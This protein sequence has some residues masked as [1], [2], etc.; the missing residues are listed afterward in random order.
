MSRIDQET[1]N[2]IL[3]AADIVDVVGDFVQLKKSGA[4]Y[5][6]LC[7]FHNERTP[8][9]SVSK[10]KGLCKCFSCG[11]GGSAVGFLM[12]L[13]QLSYVEALKYLAKKYN[14]EV[15]EHEMTDAERE[16]ATERESLFAVNTFALE[17]FEHNLLEEPDGRDIGLSYFRERGISDAAIKRFRLGYSLD[18]RD[19]LLQAAKSKGYDEKYLI[20]TG[21]CIKNDN[22][23]VYDRFKGRVMYPVFTVSGKVVAFG[24]RTL[25]SD[26]NVAKY[27]NSPESLIYTKSNELYGLYQAKQ[28]IVRKNKCILVEGY[29]DVISMS[30]SGIENVVASSGTSLTE[31]QIRLLHRFSENVTVI[32]DSDAAGI[33]ASL[34]G[35]DMLLS[36]G[37]K[38]K[39]LLLPDGDDPDS[40]A[41][42]HTLEEI[43]AYI[44]ENETDFIRFKTKILLEGAENDPIQ[45]AAVITDIVKSI[46]F[47]PD[48]ISQLVYIGECSRILQID[49]KVLKLEVE[50][51]ISQRAEAELKSPH[52]TQTPDQDAHKAA[53]DYGTSMADPRDRRAAVSGKAFQLLVSCEMNL[54]RYVLKYGMVD[55]CD[56]MN[57]DGQTVPLKLIDYVNDELEADNIEL[58]SEA[59]K[60]VFEAV[61]VQVSQYWAEDEATFMADLDKRREAFWQQGQNEIQQ[62]AVDLTDIKKK[63]I[64]L[65]EECDNMYASECER[66]TT[67]YLESRLA[68]SADDNVRRLTT[69]LVSEKYQLSKV[70][71]KYSK[72][73]TERDR[74]ID[75]VP[76]AIATLKEAHITVL[77]A[78]ERERLINLDKTQPGYA[79][80]A[81]ECLQQIDTY[82]RLRMELARNL[83]V[84]VIVPRR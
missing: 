71:S 53:V 75:L 21:L 18:R 81:A 17:E 66:F 64:A 58:V 29:M 82:T 72:V 36:E 14:I 83:G 54:L 31:G 44:A 70:Y 38:V 47:I 15:K 65:K 41:Q 61:K 4:N 73:E 74:L 33:K 5:I 25:R 26:K 79:E 8:S 40:F 57:E 6:G 52:N 12:E 34:R 11:K 35:I 43:E 19:A 10:S 39:V 84:R 51:R 27:V 67:D 20:T 9:F 7:P 3:D 55:F 1:V 37:L 56:V 69:E 80:A 63:E 49:E 2:K 28:A 60:S 13:E 78:E 30:Q 68:S 45:R 50:K 62:T 59:V 48:Q 32:Y 23:Q 46:S 24:G 16:M 22:G 42:S 77:L 76:K